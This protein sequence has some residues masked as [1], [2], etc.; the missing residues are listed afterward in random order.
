MGYRFATA[1]N[2]L[3]QYTQLHPVAATSCIEV[4]RKI[5]SFK[6][7]IKSDLTKSFYQIQK[8]KSS[9]SYLGIVTPFKGLHVYLR[10]AMGMPGS[11]GYLQ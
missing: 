5:F 8:S 4:L 11:S 10:C 7:I 3:N 6:Y 2:E 9:I 1:F